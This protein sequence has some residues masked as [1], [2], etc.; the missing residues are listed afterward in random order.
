MW[1]T[2]K[3]LPVAVNRSEFYSPKLSASRDVKQH[4]SLPF[5]D[6]L[7][8]IHCNALSTVFDLEWAVPTFFHLLPRH[9]QTWPSEN[10]L[11]RR[12][13]NMQPRNLK[14]G[15]WIS[16]EDFNVKWVSCEVHS[17]RWQTSQKENSGANGRENWCLLVLIIQG[18]YVANDIG[19]KLRSTLTRNYTTVQLTFMHTTRSLILPNRKSIPL[20]SLV[21]HIFMGSSAVAVTPTTRTDSQLAQ[22]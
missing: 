1:V 7:I 5:L 6:L 11:L 21:S 9:S 2:L 3:Y 16:T 12:W 17:N 15:R 13:T 18:V 14:N 20:G 19:H 8:K 4:G 22:R 10:S